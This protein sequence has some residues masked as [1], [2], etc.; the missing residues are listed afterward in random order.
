MATTWIEA[1]ASSRELA[2]ELALLLAGNGV[3]LVDGPEAAG[4]RLSIVSARLERVV[5]S[6]GATA[7]VREFALVYRV[8]YR[9]DATAGEALVPTT[10]LVIR[11]DYTFDERQVLGTTSEQELREREMRREMATR[12]VA[13]VSA[14]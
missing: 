3:E 1:P 7:R 14:R 9:I 6:V 11:R 2:D 12:I 4:A 5:Q 10:E 13:N 8:A